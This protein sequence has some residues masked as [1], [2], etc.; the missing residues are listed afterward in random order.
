MSLY[1]LVDECFQAQN[2][3]QPPYM[4]EKLVTS[5]GCHLVNMVNNRTRRIMDGPYP[6]NFRMSV[7]I[8]A[9]SGY[10]KSTF[11]K[12]LFHRNGLVHRHEV[13]CDMRGTFTPEAWVGTRLSRDD[14]ENDPSAIFS[15]FATGIVAI[16][17]YNRLV[18]LMDGDG[19]EREEVYLLQGLD[20]PY[21]C[22]DHSLGIIEHQNVCTTVIAA[23]R[24]PALNLKMH[25][26]LGRRFMWSL[27][28]PGPAEYMA[29]DEARRESKRQGGRSDY[30]AYKARTQEWMAECLSIL[31]EAMPDHF[32]LDPVS[33]WCAQHDQPH[34]IGNMLDR[35]AIGW[36]L[37]NDTFPRI[38]MS[39]TLERMFIDEIVS[40][41]ILKSGC[42]QHAVRS[43]VRS[44]G[45]MYEEYSAYPEQAG[46]PVMAEVGVLKCLLDY[47][48]L[49][50]AEAEGA[51]NGSVQMG[52][53][54][55]AEPGVLAAAPSI[56][57]ESI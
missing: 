25:S 14:Q 53:V 44:H 28:L 15:R 1:S 4:L 42:M 39:D 48:Q 30:S 8:A 20:T 6:E 13:P 16:E 43:I 26:G 40:R 3:Y 38:C 56:L 54:E 23:M 52:L 21:A 55:Y 19:I 7:V 11:E 24:P 9:P 17:E 50:R 41:R 45:N 10:C 51:I 33:D 47:Y 49:S 35:M 5:V 37:V 46:W 34:F 27:Q 12:M 57:E 18:L 29:L 2:L 36:S 31:P 32:D 22:K